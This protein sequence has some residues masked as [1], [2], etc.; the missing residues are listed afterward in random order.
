MLSLLRNG[1]EWAPP[2]DRWVR[3]MPQRG[4]DI[5][6]ACP[7]SLV[8]W[9]VLG[10]LSFAG[11]SGGISHVLGHQGASVMCWGISHVLGHQSCSKASVMC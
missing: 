5:A 9:D 8:A 2:E 10:H 4:G 6:A 11:A 7:H 3:R 1:T